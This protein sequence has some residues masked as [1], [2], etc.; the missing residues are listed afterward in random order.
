MLCVSEG[1]V[2]WELPA[3]ATTA[4]GQTLP[5]LNLSVSYVIAERTRAEIRILAENDQAHRIRRSPGGI[6]IQL[7]NTGMEDSWLRMERE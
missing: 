2:G 5:P 4:D 1:K 6:E 7:R 3:G